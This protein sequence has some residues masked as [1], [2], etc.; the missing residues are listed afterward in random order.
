ML[1]YKG[2]KYFNKQFDIVEICWLSYSSYSL[3]FLTIGINIKASDLLG[4]F[5]LYGKPPH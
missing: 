3:L 2:C 5:Y 4:I 1:N